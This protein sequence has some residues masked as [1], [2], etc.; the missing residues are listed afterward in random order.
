MKILSYGN[1]KNGI[2]GENDQWRPEG[3][4][5]DEVTTRSKISEIVGENG[6]LISFGH[7]TF[8]LRFSVKLPQ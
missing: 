2:Y 1:K 5:L 6:E 8:E 7:L 3:E 4:I